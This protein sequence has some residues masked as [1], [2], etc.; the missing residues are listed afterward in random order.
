[1]D[2]NHSTNMPKES[3]KHFRFPRLFPSTHPPKVHTVKPVDRANEQGSPSVP[4]ENLDGNLL[5]LLQVYF[6]CLHGF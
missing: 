5:F 1:M 4:L 2:S 6:T 3:K